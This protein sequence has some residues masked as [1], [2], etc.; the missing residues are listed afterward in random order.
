M[1]G[2]QAV[3]CTS[4]LAR[5]ADTTISY[6]SMGLKTVPLLA[7]EYGETT[8]KVGGVA[9]GSV[10]SEIQKRD[11]ELMQRS[12]N[13]PTIDLKGASQRTWNTKAERY[14]NLHKPNLNI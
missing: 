8:I 13:A 14:R 6:V 9:R 12:Y 1:L 7:P 5:N 3:P 2:M 11:P 4:D 10:A